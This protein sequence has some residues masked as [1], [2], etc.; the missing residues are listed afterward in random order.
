MSHLLNNTTRTKPFW[1]T[2]PRRL[3]PAAAL[4]AAASLPG[5]R[6]L[7]T[8]ADSLADILK[9][10]PTERNRCAALEF[11][12]RSTARL[13][14]DIPRLRQQDVHE[15]ATE[16]RAIQALFDDASRP[17]HRSYRNTE[18]KIE[19]LEELDRRLDNIADL[20]KARWLM[21]LQLREQIASEDSRLKEIDA[22][23]II[24]QKIIWQSDQITESSG[25]QLVVKISN[26]SGRIGN[27]PVTYV[28]YSSAQAPGEAEAVRA[29][30]V[31]ADSIS[32]NDERRS[33]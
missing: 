27:M 9:D 17:G 4:G 16:F 14:E 21:R 30:T 11:R 18:V 29:L 25:E 6:E 13:V 26:R 2:I 1:R 12:I 22:Y 19:M 32:M 8:I 15:F 24:D 31:T 5:F 3:L 10:S 33:V 20:I 7:A 28:T 23:E